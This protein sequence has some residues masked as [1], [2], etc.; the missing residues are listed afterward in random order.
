MT[1]LMPHQRQLLQHLEREPRQRAVL[2]SAPVGTGLNAVV[3]HF[4]VGSVRRGELVVV[5]TDRRMLVD[6]WV[7][8]LNEAEAD[9]VVPLAASSDVLMELNRS[10]S[11]LN[12]SRILIATI[13]LLSQGVGRQLA[14][15]LH[16]GVLIVDRMPGLGAGLRGELLKRLASRSGSVVVLTDTASPEWFRPT[17]SIDWAQDNMLHR[18]PLVETLSY[19]PSAHEDIVYSRAL[20]LLSNG[21]GGLVLRPRTRPAI[22]ASILRLIA[23]LSGDRVYELEDAA[24]D[25]TNVGEAEVRDDVRSPVLQEAWDVI[26]SLEELGEDGRLEATHALVRRAAKENR[27]CI[28]ITELAIEADYVAAYLQGLNIPV[29]L[30]NAEYSPMQRRQ[31]QEA[32]SERSVLVVGSKVFDLLPDLPQRIKVVWWSPP[33]TIAQS[34]LWLALAARSPQSTVIAITTQP[35]LP[36]EQELQTILN[37]LRN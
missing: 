37:A 36:G 19:Q 1:S 29:F 24:T 34:R 9:R 15:A 18:L 22:H 11:V 33:R 26:D 21:T 31:L 14:D 20:E 2:L 25:D 5:I 13:Q 23:R 10:E 4:A 12:I 6:Q 16:P 32:L 17:E 30:L 28:V 7:Y 8:Q 3:A 27:L 35:P